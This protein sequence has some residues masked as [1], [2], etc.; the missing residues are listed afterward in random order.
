MRGNLFSAIFAVVFCRRV[1]RGGRSEPQQLPLIDVPHEKPRWMTLQVSLRWP[2]W[3]ARLADAAKAAKARLN[4]EF[5]KRSFIKLH[6]NSAFRPS[7]LRKHD[8]PATASYKGGRVSDVPGEWGPGFNYDIE[9]VFPVKVYSAPRSA[10]EQAAAYASRCKGCG[11][12]IGSHQSANPD[13]S[14]EAVYICTIATPHGSCNCT[15]SDSCM[16]RD[17]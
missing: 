9:A 12:A 1:Y 2:E 15:L 3:E 17:D 14:R 13:D 8:Y 6:A 10:R 4:S 11:H 16:S 7:L 5:G